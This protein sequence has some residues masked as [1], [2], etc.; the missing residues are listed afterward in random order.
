MLKPVKSDQ[1]AAQFAVRQRAGKGTEGAPV[2]RASRRRLGSADA[3]PG[4]DQPI[5]GRPGRTAPRTNDLFTSGRLHDSALT[6]ADN[7]GGS[8]RSEPILE[9]IIGDTVTPWN[10]RATCSRLSP[11]KA[12]ADSLPSAVD[13]E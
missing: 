12:S 6:T 11:L 5:Q 9:T 2:G 13:L 8:G 10:G 4:S 7:G 3:H 1:D